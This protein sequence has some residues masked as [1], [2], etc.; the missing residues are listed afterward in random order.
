MKALAFAV[1]GVL[2][3]LAAVI[4]FSNYSLLL[5]EY[6]SKPGARVPSRIPIAGGVLGSLA[7]Y[8][9]VQIPALPQQTWSW[10][11]LLPLALD[12]GG[13]L[14]FVVEVGCVVISQRFKALVP[15]A[16]RR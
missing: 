5:K 3:L 8:V 10:W 15:R 4:I 2:G 6:A 14:F 16:R 11:I 7:L 9:Y 13:L 1:C 12:P